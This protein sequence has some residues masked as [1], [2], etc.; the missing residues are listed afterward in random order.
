MYKATDL[1]QWKIASIDMILEGNRQDCLI[2]IQGGEATV[3][4][5]GFSELKCSSWKF[6]MA[7]VA[8]I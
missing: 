2:S 7:K 5:C 4:S 3:E 1:R 8:K 6:R